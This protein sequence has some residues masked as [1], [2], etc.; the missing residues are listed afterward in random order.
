[1]ATSFEVLIE[2][3][4]SFEGLNPRFRP[5]TLAAARI[6]GR[7]EDFTRIEVDSTL[8][9]TSSIQ[10]PFFFMALMLGAA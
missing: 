9:S 7:N 4:A 5:E 6:K 1:M 10:S 3:L 2:V 8:C